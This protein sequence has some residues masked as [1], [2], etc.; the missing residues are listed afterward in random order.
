MSTEAGQTKSAPLRWLVAAILF[1][2]GLLA[3]DDWT[4]RRWMLAT[5]CL[6]ALP[7]L[8]QFV[9]FAIFRV[10]ALWF[11]VLL[12]LQT[13]LTPLVIDR[14]YITLVP[15]MSLERDVHLGAIPGI[16]GIQRITTD[17]K[18][19]RTTRHVD[20]QHKPNGHV[21]IFAI[22][23]STTEQIFLDDRRTWTHLLQEQL[24]SAARTSQ[25]EI[26]NTGVS[27]LRATHHVATMRQVIR[28]Q[29]DVV[30]IMVGVND[31]NRHIVSVLSPE[32]LEQSG[33]RKER[34][35]RE[36]WRSRFHL[37]TSAL[38]ILIE[39]L[40]TTMAVRQ[41]YKPR[42]IPETGAFLNEK[43]SSMERPVVRSF[44]PETVSAEYA[45]DLENL[46]KACDRSGAECVF[47]TQPTAYQR[48]APTELKRRFWMTPPFAEYTLDFDSVVHVS[49]M[50]NGYLKKF[51]EKHRK[52]VC[53]VAAEIAASPSNFY[54]DCH[55]T[56]EGANKVASVLARCLQRIGFESR[57]KD[58]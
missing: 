31:W 48:S 24:Q 15:R 30:L 43:G 37:K 10:Y 13:L 12:V 41:E 16:V 6:Y 34:A 9:P 20:Y 36:T 22:G 27:G 46:V 39:R 50:Y 28:Y 35:N 52:P 56:V 23:G 42:R 49:A 33:P 3:V 26:V 53:D 11:G 25:I 29:P 1:G 14:R 17:D 58:G 38:G 51:A 32:L 7:L 57:N 47:V 21:R 2:F 4:S 5:L 44:R 18:G 40:M 8:L 54:D 55:F 19:F 45:T